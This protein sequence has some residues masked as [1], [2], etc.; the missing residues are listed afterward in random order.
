MTAAEICHLFNLLLVFPSVKEPYYEKLWHHI[1]RRL[2]YFIFH[3]QNFSLQNIMWQ[4][5]IPTRLFINFFNAAVF[6]NPRPCPNM[7]NSSGDNNRKIYYLDK[8]SHIWIGLISEL[9]TVK[10]DKSLEM[11]FILRMAFIHLFPNLI[12]DQG[13]V[14]KIGRHH[15][16][17]DLWNETYP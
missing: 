14:F 17:G 7:N 4:S 1:N 5:T 11:G 2:R 3:T 12:I 9:T 16:S 10:H 13:F 15:L 8:L 6:L